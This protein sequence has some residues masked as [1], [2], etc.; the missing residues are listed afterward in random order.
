MAMWCAYMRI[1][2]ITLEGAEQEE[3][4]FDS[5]QQ[6]IDM[7]RVEDMAARLRAGSPATMV[8]AVRHVMVT[9]HVTP[10]EMRHVTLVEM[11]TRAEMR[12]AIPTAALL[13]T[14][15]P[16]AIHTDVD[17]LRRDARSVMRDVDAP[18]A[19]LLLLPLVC[20]T[21]TIR[22]PAGQLQRTDTLQPAAAVELTALDPDHAL[23]IALTPDVMRMCPLLHVWRTEIASVSGIVTLAML[24]TLLLQPPWRH[25][26]AALVDERPHAADRLPDI[27]LERW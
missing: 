9:R 11:H 26:P 8:L 12:P 24:P 7:S 15:I 10:A 16:A 27:I 5:H 1:R 4:K 13:A 17:L 25:C 14:P 3:E 19:R 6:Q 18:L 20:L 23:A 2:R 22:R 21:V